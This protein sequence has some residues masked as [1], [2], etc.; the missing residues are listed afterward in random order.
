MGDNKRSSV[1]GGSKEPGKRG[2]LL[3]KNTAREA[4]TFWKTKVPF[5]H[6]EG[7][8]SLTQ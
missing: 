4:V 5:R 2:L 3:Q 8:R 6:K 1:E 7:E